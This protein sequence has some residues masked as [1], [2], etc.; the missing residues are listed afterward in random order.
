MD[1]LPAGL[2]NT[3]AADPD[4]A[5]T[6]LA[7]AERKAAI[8][9]ALKLIH[10]GRRGY[11]LFVLTRSVERQNRILGGGTVPVHPTCPCRGRCSNGVRL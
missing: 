1:T 8:G 2:R 4:H 6:R 9:C 3:N 5:P 7:A 10:R 11:A